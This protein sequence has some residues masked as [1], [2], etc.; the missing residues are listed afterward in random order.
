MGS[1]EIKLFEPDYE[2][3]MRELKEYAEKTVKRGALAVILIGSLARGDYTAF[4]DADVIIVVE[5]SGERP[6]DRIIKYLEP[7]AS[8]DIEPRVYTTKEIQAM[9]KRGARII[10]EI[11]EHGILLSG[12]KEI[13]EEI[14][15][16]IKTES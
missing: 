5:E 7:S 13:I 9:A 1:S 11:I 14:R 4:S 15:Q 2:A 8:V 6:I 10:K 16:A 12:N 3:I